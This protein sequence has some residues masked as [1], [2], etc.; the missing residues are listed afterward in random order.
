MAGVLAACGIFAPLPEPRSL[1]QRLAMFPRERLPLEGEVTVYWDEHQIPFIE[2][3]HDRDAAFVLGLVHAHLRLGQLEILRRIAL[4]RIAEM[5]GPLATDID[6]GLRILDYGRAADEIAARLPPETRL[7]LE[8][9]AA[10]LNHYQ[11]TADELPYEYTA[12]GLER[13]PWRVRDLLAFGRLAG[14][15][16]NWLV[17]YNLIR[18]RGRDDW[19]RIWA[20]LVA[21]GG[22]ST[23][24][25]ADDRQA[26]LLRDLLA[27]FSRSGSNSLAVAASRS[28]SGGALMVND[29]HVGINVPSLWLL[30][31]VKSPSYHAVGLMIPGL[32]FFAIGRNPR[33][34]WGGTNMRA[35]ASELYD[36]SALPASDIH[37]RRARIAVRWW[38][39]REITL[40]DT[41]WGPILSDAPLLADAE[42]PPVAL[43]WTGHL[44][45]DETSAMLAVARAETFEAFRDAFESFA[46]PGQNMLYADDRGNIGQVMAVRLPKREAGTPPDLV[47]D[48]AVAERA[49]RTFA[50]VRDLPFSLNPPQGFLASGNNRPAETEIPVGYFFS[51]NDRVERMAALLRATDSIGLD[52]IMR[53][54]RDVY[55]ASA[56]A[57]RDLALAKL[58]ESGLDR[59]ATGGQAEAIALMREWD[60]FYRAE[61]R[62]ALAFELFR[63]SFS[64]AFYQS[65]FGAEDWSAFAG[66]ARIQSLLLEDI[67]DAQPDELEAALRRGLDTA[68]QGLDDFATWGEMHRLVLSHPLGLLPL[69]G[70]RFRFADYP[71]GGSSDTLMK[72]AHGMTDARHG[73]RYGSTARHISDLSDP[74]ENLFVLLGGQDG[75][76]NSST[77]LDQVPL[78]LEGRY[79]RLPLRLESVRAA[80]PHR[81]TLSP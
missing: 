14:T 55:M 52:D 21:N 12:L 74:D 26:A 25:F 13:E 68:A 69:I 18:L 1:E 2:A 34:A 29:P 40:R 36:V 20:R 77:F 32:P 73:A 11:R 5:G 30:A 58:A 59:A 76:I 7:W 46:V 50:T 61:S 66:V 38:F 47:R 63:S 27:G 62:G 3:A 51:P 39:D 43:R 78:W 53:L 24:S 81:M 9:F 80:F 41:P 23:P 42:L 31:G 37:E 70:G 60:G 56:V 8:S 16:V 6:H 44:P 17:W 57:L 48:P 33:I 19:P 10:G 15:D 79:I 45:S 49:W 67:R 35:A 54:Q 75:W 22:D 4:G 64:R 72:T 28:R 71:I 65:L